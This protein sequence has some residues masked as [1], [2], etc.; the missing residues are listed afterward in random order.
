[1]KSLIRM[2]SATLAAVALVAFLSACSI[3]VDD[4]DKEA[5]KVDIQTP[6]ADLKV[7]TSAASTDNGIPVYPGATPRPD[8]GGDKHRANVNIGAMGFGIKVIAAEYVT[9]DSPDKVKAFYLDK[10]KKFGNVLECKGT[11][12]DHG[13]KGDW[14]DN[15]ADQPVTCGDTRGDG[16]ELKTGTNHNQ[17][18]VAI[19][20]DGSGTRFGTVLVQIHGK[21]GTL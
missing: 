19:K 10:L 3:K 2:A 16:W 4:K 7:D 14:N 8:E 18:L 6:L 1:M 17:H 13:S 21:E 5:K 12:G 11:G 9:P 15:E 20:P